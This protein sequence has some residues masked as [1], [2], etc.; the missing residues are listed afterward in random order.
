MSRVVLLYHFFA[1]ATVVSAVHFAQLAAGLAAAGHAVEVWPS[2]RDRRDASRS[3]PSRSR[4]GGVQ[5]RRCWRAAL[6]QNRTIGRLV[7]T[8]WMWLHWIGRAL[9]TRGVD[10]VILGTDPPM[11]AVVA[12]F[13]RLL[14]P[15]TRIVHWSFDLYPDAAVRQGYLRQDSVAERFLR[16]VSALGL[17]ACDAIV[18]IGPCMRERLAPRAPAVLAETIVPW[19]IAP[20]RE[21]RPPDPALRR[22]LFGDVRTVLLYAGHLGAAHVAAPFLALARELRDDGVVVAFQ[23]IGEREAEI[24][25]A[26]RGIANV[27]FLPTCDATEL[28]RRLEVAN[29]HLVSLRDGWEGTVVPSKFFGA[30]AVG[31]PVIFAGPETSSVA[32]W[33][34]ELDV[35]VVLPSEPTEASSR[36]AAHA[37][38]AAIARNARDA[39]WSSHCREVERSRFSR[40]AEVGR[41]C[42]LVGASGL[43]A[44]GGG[45]GS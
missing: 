36:G 20:S 1:P 14:R 12:R 15:G 42:R 33:T 5:V 40:E 19:A 29:F 27:R 24:R 37:V 7:N 13:W 44:G 16:G 32:R 22:A 17:R 6:S 31:R 26:A 28:V 35:G 25:E 18:D 10:V 8:L 2:N 4:S 3:L 11:S 34:R 38:R 43:T 23:A 41:W 39:A 45:G 9:T 21:P 30:L